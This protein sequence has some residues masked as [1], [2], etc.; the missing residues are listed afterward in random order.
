MAHAAEVEPNRQLQT[1]TPPIVKFGKDLGVV[2]QSSTWSSTHSEGTASN[3]YDGNTDG[4]WVYYDAVQNSVSASAGVAGDEWW[5]VDLSAGMGTPVVITH[6]TIYNRQDCCWDRLNGATVHLLDVNGQDITPTSVNNVLT[7]STLAQEILFP[8]G[9]P[10]VAVV[11]VV[12]TADTILQLAE[13]DI[14]GHEA[15]TK[16]IVKF[17]KD[18]GVVSQSSS[19]SEGTASN[20]Y[21]GNTNGNWV[22]GDAVQ[23]SVSHTLDTVGDEWWQV[24]LSAGIGEPV[25]ITHI[26]IYNRQDCCWDRLI[27]A[28]VH[29]LDVNGQDITPTSVNNVLT[30]STAAQD[31]VFFPAVPNVAVVKVVQTADTALQLAEV[32][33]FGYERTTWT[34]FAERASDG[35]FTTSFSGA[36][37][38]DHMNKDPNRVIHRYCSSCSASTHTDIYYKRIT[39]VPAQ[40]AFSGEATDFVNLFTDNWMTT[41]LNVLDTDFKLYSTYD[42]AINNVNEWTYCNYDDPTVGFP[43]DCGPNGKI[44]HQWSKSTTRTWVFEVEGTPRSETNPVGPGG[45][46]HFTTW[47]N[48]HFE[49]HGQCDLTLVKD[50]EFA[51]ALGLDIQIRTKVVRFWSYIKNVAIKIGNDILEIE[52][53]VDADDADA[54]Y[55]INFEYQGEL[56]TFA[57]FPVTQQLPSTYKRRYIIDLS[58]K[59]PGASIVVQLYKEFARVQFN[60]DQSVF[61]NTVGLLGDFKT[62]ELLARDGSTVMNDFADFGDEW[63]VLPSEDKLF[64]EIAHP[65]FPELCIK[66]EDPRG[67]RKRRL[68]E[69]NI[70]IEK[71]ESVCGAALTDPL[72]IKDCVYDILATQDLDM[73]GAF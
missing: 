13:L 23:N 41:P 50:A 8:G 54:H 27:G 33:I 5:Q 35:T 55:W 30:G 64:H 73:V 4:N 58:S 34:T 16:P 17:G 39:N 22:H 40:S 47:N 12:Q 44:D 3:A 37:I 10:N 31:I 19:H 59:Y 57:G 36:A 71:A 69:S 24:D 45:D 7:G 63:Q 38:A 48:E 18:L 42:D 56:D 65:Q 6:I 62:G 60:G 11:K 28:T 25:V 46:P 53:S 49:Y 20:A 72:S 2:S 51:E 14:F 26:T 21:D 67:E 32:D 29:L 68:E 66:P 15:V 43:R 9:V 52:G 70:S 61:G 1:V